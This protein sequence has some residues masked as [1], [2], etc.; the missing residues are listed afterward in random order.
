ME[1]VDLKKQY[2]CYRDEL[3]REIENVLESASFIRGPAVSDLESELAEYVGVKHA[4]GCSS[5]TDA[6]FLGLLARRGQLESSFWANLPANNLELGSRCLPN[7]DQC[8]P[9][10]DVFIVYGRVGPDE[11]TLPQKQSLGSRCSTCT[12]L[13]P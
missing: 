1:F 6:L 3:L 13:G 2:R 7:P 9:P 10:D 8:C 11:L 12:L 5:G 4:I